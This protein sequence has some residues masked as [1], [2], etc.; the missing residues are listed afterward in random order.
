MTDGRLFGF[1]HFVNDT[2]THSLRAEGSEI[3]SVEEEIAA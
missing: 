3:L 2:Y 1:A